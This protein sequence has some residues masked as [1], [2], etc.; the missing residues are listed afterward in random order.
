MLFKHGP[1][2]EEKAAPVVTESSYDDAM[3]AFKE[4]KYAVAA[5]GFKSIADD[6]SDAKIASRAK[7]WLEKLTLHKKNIAKRSRCFKNLLLLK[8]QR[9]KLTLS[10]CWTNL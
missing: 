5:E 1:K 7:Y 4:H 9:R 8:I 10:S 2:E 3:T 6:P